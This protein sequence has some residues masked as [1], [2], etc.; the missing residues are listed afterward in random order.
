MNPKLKFD[1]SSINL[2]ADR[3]NDQVNDNYI[4]ARRSDIQMRGYLTKDDLFKIANWKSPRSSGHVQKNTDDYIAEITKFAFSTK[5][6]RAKIQTLTNLDGV[7][8]PTASVILHMFDK[9]K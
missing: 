3:Y 2:Y 1:E 7:S 6:E 5:C 4:I 8:W 9:G